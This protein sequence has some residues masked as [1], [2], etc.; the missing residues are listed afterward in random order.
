MRGTIAAM[1]AGLVLI[2]GCSGEDVPRTSAERL[3]VVKSTAQLSY[4]AFKDPV[5]MLSKSDIAVVGTIKSVGRVIID[6]ELN[7]HGGAIVTVEPRE[8]W[9]RPAGSTGLVYY[10]LNWPR[11]SSL[12]PL[13]S[14]LPEDSEIVLF[15][16]SIVGRIK[17][18]AGR[19]TGTVFEPVA[20]GLWMG[21]N[22]G[23]IS[24]VWG[25]YSQ[26]PWT[27]I[28]SVDELRKATGIS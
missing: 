8:V 12:E 6:D 27:A 17:L 26:S 11:D 1:I 20:E 5:E 9:K 24:N 3:S 19:P 23:D 28:D 22:A 15:G 13:E 21:A 25:E 16:D 18:G 14:A 10:L 2:S 7:D 4:I